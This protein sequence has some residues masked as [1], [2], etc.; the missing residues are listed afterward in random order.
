MKKFFYNNLKKS[1][2]GV[3]L[4]EL[5]VV[6]AIIGVIATIGFVALS[7][8]S[9]SANDSKKLADIRSVQSALEAWR[10]NNG[11]NE[12]YPGSSNGAS[13]ECTDVASLT[14]L[15]IDLGFATGQEYY[16][17]VSTTTDPT[18][19]RLVTRLGDTSHSALNTDIDTN[20]SGVSADTSAET[21]KLNGGTAVGAAAVAKCDCGDSVKP[22]PT[23]AAGGTAVNT[24]AYCV[25]SS[26]ITVSG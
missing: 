9:D 3:T 17:Q 23:R 11:N 1:R 24:G 25:G 10:N 12:N 14:G 16:Y 26:T 15:G 20:L 18:A 7:G 2:A 13:S 6:V 22:G 8:S 19:Y 4:I 5:L 21:T